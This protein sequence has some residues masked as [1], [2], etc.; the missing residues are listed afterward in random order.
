M[1]TYDCVI[2]GGGLA[3]ASAAAVLAGLG[4]NVLLAEKRRTAQHKVCGEFLSPESQASLRAMG[5]HGTVAALNPSLMHEA[6][7]VS[8][9]G[10][11][12]RVA[13]P[14]QAWGV[15]RLALD[16]ALLAAAAAAGTQVQ[17]GVAALSVDQEGANWLVRL[18][19]TEGRPQQIRTRTVLVACGRH[20]PAE[21]RPASDA[22]APQRTSYVGVKCHY[23]GLALPPEVQLYMFDGGYAG[24]SPVEG[25]YANLCLL[26]SR[27]A[28]TR[29]GGTAS[30]MLAAATRWNPAL[31][32]ALVG[33]T[34]VAGSEVAVAP[35]DTGRPAVPWLRFPRLGDAAT[36]IPPLC[37]D[38]MAMALR[39]AELCAPLAHAVLAGRLAPAAWEQAYTAAW[40]AEFDPRL[41]AGRRLQALLAAPLLG[42]ALLAAG[43]LFPAAAR[44]VVAA[45]RGDARLA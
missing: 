15:S 16:A 13:L 18:R 33:G 28:F 29:A 6:L 31:A 36:M 14:G 3:G 7:L 43:T 39:S 17:R 27:A 20:P 25:G 45:T 21:L 44:R 10:V 12:L 35:V 11:Q 40:H 32:A 26:A 4:W 19:N 1:Q 23:S 8:R 22:A 5:L 34:P 30:T 24:L 2:I 38:G 9:L 42:D 41:R 37:G